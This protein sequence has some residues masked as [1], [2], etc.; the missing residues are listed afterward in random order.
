MACLI[1][2]GIGLS[3]ADLRRVAGVFKKVWLFNTSDLRTN[4]DVT[5]NFLTTINFNTYASLYAFEGR[6]YTHTYEEK[7]SRTEDGNAQIE[8]TLTLKVLNSSY[9]EDQVLENL[10]VAEVGA[11]LLNNNKEFFVAGAGNGLDCSEQNST[12]GTKI[13][14]PIST[15]VILKGTEQYK[16]KRLILPASA[17]GD[18]FQSTMYWLNALTNLNITT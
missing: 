7:G 4:I 3:C 1:G 15:T 14:D 9:Q 2:S 16:A 18:S 5:Q 11:I 13:G 17:Q 6:K 10:L 8:Q 12:T